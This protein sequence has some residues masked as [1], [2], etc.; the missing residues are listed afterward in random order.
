MFKSSTVLCVS[1]ESLIFFSPVCSRHFHVT[2]NLF[3]FQSKEIRPQVSGHYELSQCFYVVIVIFCFLLIA[4]CY[5]FYRTRLEELRMFLENETWELCPVKSSF[6][7]IQ[8]HVSVLK[9]LWELFGMVKDMWLLRAVVRSWLS[10]L[11]QLKYCLQCSNLT[12]TV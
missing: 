4:E 9:T 7:I 12:C 3:M 5:L 2:A 10:S 11:D 6:S 8:L 1:L